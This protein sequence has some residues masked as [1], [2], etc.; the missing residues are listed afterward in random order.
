MELCGL[1]QVF[2]RQSIFQKMLLYHIPVLS[3]ATHEEVEGFA[4][5]SA[6]SSACPQLTVFI[7]AI[8]KSVKFWQV[9]FCGR[10]GVVVVFYHLSIVSSVMHWLYHCKLGT[11]H[12]TKCKAHPW[13]HRTRKPLAASSEHWSSTH[14]KPGINEHGQHGQHGPS[15]RRCQ[16]CHYH[17]C[18]WGS[19][20]DPWS[21]SMDSLPSRFQ[22]E[23]FFKYMS[24]TSIIC[25]TFWVGPSVYHVPSR[26]R[27]TCFTVVFCN[28]K[29]LIKIE[30]TRTHEN[31]RCHGHNKYTRGWKC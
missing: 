25:I 29:I 28:V 5:I 18:C 1:F 10:F 3:H 15:N 17:P 9:W 14:D 31:I 22:R 24:S 7:Q 11:C 20:S 16:W 23:W 27:C 13:P 21:G 19:C 6:S 4:L 12:H 8:S 30:Q 26:L 2:T